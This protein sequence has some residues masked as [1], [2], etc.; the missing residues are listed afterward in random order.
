MA[1][2]II[3]KVPGYLKLIGLSETSM[4]LLTANNYLMRLSYDSGAKKRES[5]TSED[6][7]TPSHH[8]VKYTKDCLNVAKVMCIGRE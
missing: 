7:P 1:F 2:G 5:A 6:G 3:C 4:K 8:K